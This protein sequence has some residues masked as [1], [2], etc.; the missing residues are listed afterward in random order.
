MLTAPTIAGS[1]AF[2]EIRL[3]DLVR[4]PAAYFRQD[5]V[6]CGFA[7][8][9]REDVNLFMTREPARHRKDER[10]VTVEWC[11]G[12]AWTPLNVRPWRCV[13]GRFSTAGDVELGRDGQPDYG[14]EQLVDTGSPFSWALTQSCAPDGEPAR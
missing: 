10:G 3:K 13:K 4:N 8:D 5:V 9:R 14:G 2:A 6:T 1:V 7:T 11:P 12:S